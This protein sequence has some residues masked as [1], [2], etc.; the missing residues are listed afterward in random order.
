MRHQIIR[1]M[2]V[3]SVIAMIVALTRDCKNCMVRCVLGV[4]GCVMSDAYYVKQNERTSKMV[5]TKK[6]LTVSITE[7]MVEFANS[8][9]NANATITLFSIQMQIGM[10]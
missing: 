5:T 2:E 9:A 6:K 3:R 1:K 4:I 8:Y 7:Y 10:H